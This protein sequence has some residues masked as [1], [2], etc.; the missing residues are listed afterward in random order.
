MGADVVVFGDSWGT[1]ARAAFQDM[2]RGAATVDNRAVGGTFAQTWALTPNALRDA[3]S[4]NPTASHVWL[5]LGGNDGIARLAIGQRP[6]EDIV[7]VKPPTLAQ[8]EDLLP[9][10][11][12][13]DE[14]NYRKEAGSLG[15]ESSI[16]E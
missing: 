11:L 6:I 10:L 8:V 12:E 1:G 16:V 13:F 15:I 2:F 9:K 14:I 5:S 4:A 7:E 3:V